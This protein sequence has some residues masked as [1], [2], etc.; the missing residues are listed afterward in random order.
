MGDAYDRVTRGFGA[1]RAKEET[2]ARPLIIRAKCR[3]IMSFS[4]HL[5]S[6]PA[7]Q[8][9]SHDSQP[10]PSPGLVGEQVCVYRTGRCSIA[11][12]YFL[13]LSPSLPLSLFSSL[14]CASP[15]Y[16]IRTRGSIL[17]RQRFISILRLTLDSH[18]ITKAAHRN[19]ASRSSDAEENESK[20]QERGRDV[21]SIVPYICT[22]SMH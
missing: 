11:G 15:W 9:S 12:P 6:A 3:G 20:K 18:T 13:S 14:L 8:S 19:G 22:H 21:R 7:V 4:T 16:I 5:I 17:P 10:C 1:E 2:S